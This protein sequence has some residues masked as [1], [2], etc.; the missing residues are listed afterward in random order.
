[1][2]EEMPSETMKKA[3]RHILILVLFIQF[4]IDRTGAQT[5]CIPFEQLP[6][7]TYAGS[8]SGMSP[9]TIDVT[10]GETLMTVNNG[11]VVTFDLFQPSPGV[12]QFFTLQ[13]TTSPINANFTT[14][15]GTLL[16]YAGMT[17][18]F[19][20]ANVNGD[21]V[22]LTFDYANGQA[23]EINLQINGGDTLL[24][25]GFNELHDSMVAPG[26]FL[27][28]IIDTNNPESG[29]VTLCGNI[30]SLRI[31]GADLNFDNLCYTLTNLTSVWPGDMNNN[32]R[33][34]H[35]DLL[36]LGLAFGA[37]RE[38]CPRSDM[39]IAWNPILTED[40]VESFANGLNF[41]YADANGDGAILATDVDAIA[42]NFFLT[43]PSFNQL[44]YSLR[45]PS[46][47]PLYVNTESNYPEFAGTYVWPNGDALN[48]DDA[49]FNMAIE[50]ANVANIVD[51]IYG[52]SFT[53]EFDPTFLD[54][55]TV[56]LR[57]NHPGLTNGGF[58]G[59]LNNVAIEYANLDSVQFG[60]IHYAVSR[61]DGNPISGSGSVA[62]LD[63][64]IIMDVVGFSEVR[65]TNVKTT[66]LETQ[67]VWV[68]NP[69]FGFQ[70]ID[71]LP[72][73]IIN[74]LKENIEVSPNPANDFIQITNNNSKDINSIKLYNTLGQLIHT[75][76][77]PGAYVKLDVGS[78]QKG[79]YI[80]EFR[81]GNLVVCKKIKIS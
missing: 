54:P 33:A 61:T 24:I 76:N 73:S 15:E 27:E 69:V 5:L 31:G 23:K 46:D 49:N 38:G 68:H 79:I 57:S 48:G 52:L 21:V 36:N 13:T 56:N 50:L 29:A 78:Y 43:N 17:L 60:I 4:A 16:Y 18:N 75:I 41:K 9:D 40:W 71:S 65:I 12:N 1:M 55:S 37:D 44:S 59:Q 77:R 66:D 25:N 74:V 45:A 11:V 51:S 35:H 7:T 67:D 39:S 19:D 8:S 64:I 53:L 14:S 3:I 42:N 47:P 22:L 34:D 30:Q 20:F 28:H 26:V 32:G 80:L 70:V 2:I 62:V 6:L 81:F 72:T 10:L 58:F 63:G